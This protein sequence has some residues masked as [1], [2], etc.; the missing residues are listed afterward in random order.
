M[1]ALLT[2]IKQDA[3]KF[4]FWVVT[5]RSFDDGSFQW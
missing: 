1:L 2:A 3:T 5:L 4:L